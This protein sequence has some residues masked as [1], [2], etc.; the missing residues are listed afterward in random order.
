MYRCNAFWTIQRYGSLRCF[1]S[2]QRTLSLHALAPHQRFS[3]L[4]M[5]PRQI[6]SPSSFLCSISGSSGW[7]SCKSHIVATAALTAARATEMAME[8]SYFA[9]WCSFPPKDGSQCLGE[10]KR[11]LNPSLQLLWGGTPPPEP[12]ISRPGSLPGLTEQ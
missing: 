6:V 3:S 2:H 4:R 1:H 8:N 10:A 5:H 11:N 9:I 7:F 12:Q